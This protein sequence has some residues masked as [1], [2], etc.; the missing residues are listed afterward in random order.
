MQ[1]KLIKKEITFVV[2]LLFISVS[3]I[4]STGINIVGKS[5]A[6]SNDGN[7][8]YVGGSGPGNYSTIQ[9]AIDNAS[10]GDIIFVYSGWYDVDKWIN[11]N[12]SIR[13][14]G[15]DKDNT[16]INDSGIS[17][18]VSEVCVSGFTI[19]NGSGITI[20][21]FSMEVANNNSISGNIF[22]SHKSFIG[23]GGITISN[24]SYNTI[25]NNSFF[26]CGIWMEAFF[27]LDIV[28]FYPNFVYNN[29]VNGKPLV[30]FEDI[31][32]EVIYDAGQVILIKCN[33]ITVKDLELSNTIIGVQLLDSLNCYILGNTFSNTFLGGIL[34][35]NSNN[36]TISGNTI[37]DNGLGAWLHY[38]RYNTISGNS[39]KNNEINFII[40]NSTCNHILNNNFR[41]SR[42][43]RMFKS[44]F[45][46]DSE[47]KWNSNF[48][49]RPRLLPVLIWGFK[50]TPLRMRRNLD[51]DWRPA[52]KPNDTS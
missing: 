47:N 40:F 45:S 15:E 42:S 17:I 3:V 11:I 16:I 27:N 50:T 6:M 4:P 43:F 34:L 1:K 37:S 2:I 14:T 21:S 33:N 12:K 24:S 8:L 48:W 22:K 19:Q 29:T 49:N 18:V 13:L 23:F 44:I 26:D 38:S 9:E 30:Y 28:T 36:N 7:T 52:L 5:S 25:S 35:G 41:F 31:S 32:D 46:F 20:T 10:D 51:I 39:F